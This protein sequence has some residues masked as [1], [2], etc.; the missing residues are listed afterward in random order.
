MA[1]RDAEGVLLLPEGPTE[2]YGAAPPAF[3]WLAAGKTLPRGKFS[4][5]FEA[6]ICRQPHDPFGSAGIKCDLDGQLQRRATDGLDT[7]SPDDW[8]VADDLLGP[9][10]TPTPA[11]PPVVPLVCSCSRRRGWSVGRET[12]TCLPALG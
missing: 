9:A 2:V 3:G 11:W 1:L 12:G 10:N 5:D 6:L 7:D 4:R 8:V